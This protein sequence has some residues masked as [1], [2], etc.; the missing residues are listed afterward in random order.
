MPLVRYAAASGSP[1]PA[2]RSSSSRRA[3]RSQQSFGPHQEQSWERAGSLW[4]GCGCCYL[5]ST[6]TTV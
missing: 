4:M 2:D 3:L 6:V 1:A 5:L